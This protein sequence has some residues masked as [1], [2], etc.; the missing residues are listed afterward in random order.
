EGV[1]LYMMALPSFFLLITLTQIGLPIAISKRVAEA[2]AINHTYKIKQIITIS[3]L[4]IACTSVF[5]TLSLFFS[6]PFIALYLLTDEQTLYPIKAVSFAIPLIA[7]SSIIKGYFQGMKNMKPQSYSIV[8]EQVVR[9]SIV[10]FLIKLLLPYG[11]EFAATGAI[12]SI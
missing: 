12:I 8:I 9:I 7:I 6:A 2:N 10:Y 3:I 4:I 5:F 1:G 11:I